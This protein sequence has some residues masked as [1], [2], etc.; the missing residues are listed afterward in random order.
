MPG[1]GASAEAIRVAAPDSG[2]VHVVGVGIG[3]GGSGG[4]GGGGLAK[5][6]LC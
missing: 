3:L 4:E 2:G 1:V 5:Y 6:C